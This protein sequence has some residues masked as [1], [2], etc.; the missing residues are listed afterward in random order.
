[1]MATTVIETETTVEADDDDDG[2]NNNSSSRSS[3]RSRTSKSRH[4]NGD[5]YSG[6]SNSSSG[7]AAGAIKDRSPAS[8]YNP[9]QPFSPTL[10]SSQPTSAPGHPQNGQLSTPKG[11]TGE[12]GSDGNTSAAS[13]QHTT[14]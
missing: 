14:P 2:G 11:A 3:S 8:T 6:S 4:S 13:T 7:G 1:M 5:G 10:W 9:A 12:A